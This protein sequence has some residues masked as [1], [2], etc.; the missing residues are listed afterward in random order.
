MVF[1]DADHA[2]AALAQCGDED[3]GAVDGSV[4]GPAAA[5]RGGDSGTLAP[6]EFAASGGGH[7]N[8]EAVGIALTRRC[9]GG[10]AGRHDG[11][12]GQHER[13]QRRDH[14]ACVMA[15]RGREKPSRPFR[16]PA[17]L[18]SPVT[19]VARVTP[20]PPVRARSVEALCRGRMGPPSDPLTARRDKA[21]RGV[22]LGRRSRAA[23]ELRLP[24]I[25]RSP[26]GDN[27]TE[28]RRP[29][30]PRSGVE[31]LSPTK[32]NRRQ[33]RGKSRRRSRSSCARNDPPR[34]RAPGTRP[35]TGAF[36]E[37]I[38][39]FSTCSRRGFS[40]TSARA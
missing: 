24:D 5:V 30:A 1:A 40:M 14:A 18:M 17:T 12:G 7:L 36:D 25:A 33:Q 27:R 19:P 35:R 34:R 21:C 3:D 28:W 20:S 23:F 32:A 4:G 2:A 11:R 26:G 22:R 15:F 37:S 29:A 9:L 39:A 31:L 10:G 6:G 38:Q 16:A 13:G 8:G